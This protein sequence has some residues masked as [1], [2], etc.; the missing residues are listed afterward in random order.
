MT[1]NRFGVALGLLL[2]GT[3]LAATACTGEAPPAAQSA[4][5]ELAEEPREPA[6]V[7][8]DD[9]AVHIEDHVAEMAAASGGAFVIHD[10]VADTDL[11]LQLDL[12]HKERLAHTAEHTYFVCADFK[13]E[14]GKTYDLDFWVHN[15]PDGLQ[16]TESMVHKEEGQ[17]RYTWFEEGGVWVRK[18]V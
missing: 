16:V 7:T 13:T 4:V 8:I 3:L 9:V 15:T 6:P 1:R 18:P 17:P 5:K 2:A 10:D 12:V 14:T 11:S